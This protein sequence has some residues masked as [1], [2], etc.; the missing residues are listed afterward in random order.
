MRISS[1]FSH[2]ENTT[3]GFGADT[4]KRQC[5]PAANKKL[6]QRSNPES[7]LAAAEASQTLSEEEADSSV[8]SNRDAKSQE[9]HA[10]WI[11]LIS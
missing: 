2:H 8:I 9:R 4:S 7:H 11:D 3:K 5:L 6:R 10:A 1:E